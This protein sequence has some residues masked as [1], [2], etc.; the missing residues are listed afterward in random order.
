MNKK[1]QLKKLKAL[2]TQW[3]NEAEKDSTPTTVLISAAFALAAIYYV[4]NQADRKTFLN[5]A[6][7][8]YDQYQEQAGDATMSVLAV[9]AGLSGKQ[10]KDVVN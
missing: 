1:Q 10:K 6:G 4:T 2:V 8:F 7:V 9:L 5:H 3:I